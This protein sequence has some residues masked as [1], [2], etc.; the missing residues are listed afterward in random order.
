VSNIYTTLFRVCLTV[1]CGSYE[2]KKTFNFKMLIVSI[3][4]NR[5]E[6]SQEALACM[7]HD[8]SFLIQHGNAQVAGYDKWPTQHKKEQDMNCHGL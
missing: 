2:G 1:A 7:S 4:R 6:Q 8:Q 3:N 5:G